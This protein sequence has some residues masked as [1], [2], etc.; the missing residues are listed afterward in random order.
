MLFYRHGPGESSVTFVFPNALVKSG[1]KPV[2][3]KR[4][5]ASAARQKARDKV[6]C[7]IAGL[8]VCE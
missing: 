3:T 5:G 8:D 2:T 1:D 6:S 7:W 4:P